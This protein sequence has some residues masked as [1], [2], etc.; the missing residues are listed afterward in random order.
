MDDEKESH[1]AAETKLFMDMQ[2]LNLVKGKERSEEE[3]AKLFLAAGFSNYKVAR[4][5]GLRSIIEVFP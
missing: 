3:W 5:L 2:M 4:L 1:E